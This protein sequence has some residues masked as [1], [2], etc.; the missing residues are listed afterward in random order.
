MI[1]SLR[2]GGS[3]LNLIEANNCF[4]LDPWWNPAVEMQAEERIHRIGQT[5]PVN[6]VRFVVEDSIEQRMLNLHQSKKDLF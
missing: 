2:A 1:I 3:G 5:R 4:I 6:I